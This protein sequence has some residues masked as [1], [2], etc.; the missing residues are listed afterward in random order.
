MSEAPFKAATCAI[1]PM[2]LKEEGNVITPFNVCKLIA[3]N[4][5]IHSVSL[6]TFMAT[7]EKVFE[8]WDNQN[9]VFEK[10]DVTS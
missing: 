9:D 1:G 5:S 10:L 4:G 6:S 8:L 2:L 7:K 3:V